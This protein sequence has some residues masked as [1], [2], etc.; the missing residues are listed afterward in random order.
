[1]AW[2]VPR[3][4]GRGQGV[5]GPLQGRPCPRGNGATFCLFPALQR[6]NLTQANESG[7]ELLSRSGAVEAIQTPKLVTVGRRNQISAYPDDGF[8]L[9]GTRHNRG[10]YHRV[11]RDQPAKTGKHLPP[12]AKRARLK[13]TSTVGRCRS[14]T[15]VPP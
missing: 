5:E 14:W 8:G 11:S 13:P 4:Q 1:M 6:I 10:F 3:F 9:D 15:E 12:K 7:I 2:G